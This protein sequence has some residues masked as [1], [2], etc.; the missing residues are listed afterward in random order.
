MPAEAI[1][2]MDDIW[3]FIDAAPESRALNAASDLSS[4]GPGIIREILEEPV[5]AF[6]GFSIDFTDE[7]WDF[8]PATSMN[9]APSVLRI[10]FPE[11]PL[12]NPVKLFLLNQI[13]SRTAKLQTLIGKTK[14]LLGLLRSGMLKHAV[15]PSLVT[16]EDVERYLTWRE[17]QSSDRTAMADSHALR[18]FLHFYDRMFAPV[19]DTTVFDALKHYSERTWNNIRGAE[20]FRRIPEEYLTNL[21]TTCQDIVK[22]E[23]ERPSERITAATLLILSQT[24]LRISELLACKTGSLQILA[25]HAG[26]PD[27]AYM[28]YFR[29]KG[30]KGDNRYSDARTILNPIALDAYRWLDV[31]CRPYRERLG[32]DTLIVYP[33]QKGTYC[34]HGSF[35]SMEWRLFAMHADRFKARNTQ[36]RFPELHATAMSRVMPLVPR[37]SRDTLKQTDTLVFPTPHQFRPTVATG[38][39]EQGVDPHFIQEHLGHSDYDVT[40]SY[41]RD[42]QAINRRY[43]E[44]VYQCIVEDGARPIGPHADEF[45]ARIQA[46][47]DSE[48]NGRIVPDTETLERKLARKFPLIK[49]IGGMCI[50]CGDIMPCEDMDETNKIYCAFRICPNQC[51]MYFMADDTLQAVR[52]M[53]DN[54]QHNLDNGYQKAAECELRKLQWIIRD[55]LIPE[56]DALDEQLA[57][58]GRDRVLQRFPE[59]DSIIDHEDTIRKEIMTW[60]NKQTSTNE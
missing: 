60:Q 5:I 16:T 25:G 3:G 31:H 22:D 49:K 21:I 23:N 10:H 56:L 48:M 38:M 29:T 27:I 55:E 51:I 14:N 28:T 47:I 58:I 4:D 2:H 15:N 6:R 24:G 52:T 13:T 19:A 26:F 42:D 32:V 40:T 35:S 8:T 54:Y 39:L 18:D 50:R 46:F 57:T 44:T 41:F 34:H 59:L 53:Q 17:T 43:S 36:E 9:I 7:C 20:G 11:F 12:T 33:R 37:K 1:K 45:V 30:M